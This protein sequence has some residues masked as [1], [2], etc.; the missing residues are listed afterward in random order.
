MVKT[1][2]TQ[3]LKEGAGAPQFE[4]KGTD[5]KIYSLEMFAKSEAILVIFICNHCPYVKA[6]IDDIVRIQSRFKKSELQVICINS[7]DPS[8]DEEGFENMKKFYE[9]YQ[10]NFP[11]LIDESQDVAR[12]YGAV[13]TPDP[14]LFNGERRLVY[15]GRINDAVE[16]DSIAKTHIMEDNIKA[17]LAGGKIENGFDPSIGCSIKWK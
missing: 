3:V 15:H 6:R 2:S 5:N 7:N 11:Y 8:Y 10:L 13:C 17:L 9:K 16:P 14:Y 4:L 1:E 12:R